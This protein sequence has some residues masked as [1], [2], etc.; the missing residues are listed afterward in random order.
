M[1]LCCVFRTF[2][3]F[4]ALL[5]FFGGFIPTEVK[6]I[7]SLPRVVPWFPLLRP[8]G[9]SWASHSTLIYT[10]ELIVCS[11]I[12][13]HSA[14]RHNI[15]L[16]PYFLFPAIHHLNCPRLSLSL[17]RVTVGLIQRSWV[18][19]PAKSKEFLSYFF[20]KKYLLVG[21]SS[22]LWTGQWISQWVSEWVSQ[23]VSEWEMYVCHTNQIGSTINSQS[24]FLF[25]K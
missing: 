18:Q 21:T 2:C 9:L 23:W 17:G 20:L 15:H 12:C 25:Q 6:R 4:F 3:T 7:F 5:Y 11:T 22:M 10:S 19:F 16:Y 24:N 14:T 1:W 8:V 13:V